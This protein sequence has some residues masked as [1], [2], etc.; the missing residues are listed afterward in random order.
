MTGKMKKD[1]KDLIPYC[2][3][4][5]IPNLA[6]AAKSG[7]AIQ[8]LSDWPM[9]SGGVVVFADEGLVDMD[10]GADTYAVFIQNQTDAADEATVAAAG[11]LGTQFTIVG[12]DVADVL[13]ILIVG[14]L[15]G[16]LK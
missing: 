7:V 8:Y 10:V 14:T 9:V 6:A 16:Q 12:P 5:G 15:K 4:Q 1:A 13:D 3:D 2:D 11:K